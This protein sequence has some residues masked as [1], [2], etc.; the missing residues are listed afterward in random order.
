[1]ERSM[2]EPDALS[3]RSKLAYSIGTVLNDLTLPMWFSYSLVFYHRVVNFTTASAGYLFLIGQIVG[4]VSI[5]FIGLVSD[6]TRIGLFHY[7]RRKTWHLIG[8]ICTLCSFPFCFNLCVGCK[9]SDLR[10]QFIYYT[11]FIIISQFGI[12]CSQVV[13]LA[14]INELTHQDSERVALYAYRFAWAFISNIFVYG[15]ASILLGFPSSN[16]KNN[17][18]SA[19]AP[20]FRTLAFI[21]VGFGFICM[22]IFHVGLKESQ[23]PAE[24]TQY[25]LQLSSSERLKRMTWKNFLCEKEFYQC[26]FIWTCARVILNVT[27]I[28]IPLCIIDTILTLNRVFV[29]IAPLCIC[30]IGVLASFPMRALNKR[31]GRNLTS[32]VGFGFILVSVILF[33]FIFDLKSNIQIEIAIISTCVLLGI[34]IST[35]IICSSA[36]ASD[37]IGSNTECV[38]FVYAIMSFTDKIADGVVIAIIQQ[39]N[40][41]TLSSTRICALYY[42]Y[43][44]TFISSGLAIL[45]I[46][47]ILSIWKTNIGG[48]RYEIIQEGQNDTDPKT[49]VAN[50]N[51]YSFLLKILINNYYVVHLL[52]ND[53]GFDAQ[54]AGYLTSSV[55]SKTAGK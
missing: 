27:R 16:D 46:I 4:A 44:V 50:E 18:T 52:G 45:S 1:M 55:S 5:I 36:L 43:I 8:V 29:A 22:I 40:P 34:G 17:I 6:R 19:D 21:V 39:F 15:M 9:D 25:H 10:V 7:G 33:W 23:Q 24:E 28:F 49:E 2:S 32:I 51:K 11:I 47:M 20:I 30:I 12:S 35:I 14:M 3:E 38:A 48:N 31:L 42:R 13:H 53:L 54:I 41:C 37:L 26:T